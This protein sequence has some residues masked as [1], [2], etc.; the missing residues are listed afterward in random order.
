MT[1][2]SK[3]FVVLPGL[4][5]RRTPRMFAAVALLVSCLACEAQQTGTPSSGGSVG[6]VSNSAA[7]Q[8]APASTPSNQQP[9]SPLNQVLLYPGE[10]FHIGVGDLLS[11]NVY[12]APDYL[13]TVR[14]GL[15]GTV[16]LPYIG[17]IQVAGLSVHEAQT[18]IA[19]RL[20]GAGIY[21]NPD[22][23]IQV[24]DTVN[25]TVAITGEM[26]ATVP[27]T[28]QRSLRDVLLAAGGL[29][30]SASHTV[31]IVRPGVVQPITVELGP[32]LAASA[33]ADIPIQP[34][35][36]IQVSRASVVY[37]LGAFRS[38]GAVPLDQ[39]TPLT[40]MQLAALSGGIN[41]E[42]RYADL[43]LV[44]TVGAER[45]LVKVDIKRVIDGKAPDPVLQSN[46]IIFLPTNQM[47]AVLKNLGVG[48]VL[49]LVSL[50]YTLHNY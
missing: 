5:L 32:D 45:K 18:A 24:L 20:R 46:D 49:G 43:R 35:D 41:Y 14:V 33:T 16:D 38:Q 42:G 17:A 36:V 50:I 6:A 44:R 30:A 10:D 23:V 3:R 26:H 15:D 22:V 29:P 27:V 2:E 37:V 7:Q 48:G 4:P 39:A 40:L 28:S 9:A 47:K 25:G 19:Q 11:V 1:T 21:L 12:L 34:H 8:I 31:K 13:R